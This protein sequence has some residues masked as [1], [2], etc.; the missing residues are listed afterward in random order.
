MVLCASAAVVWC[1]LSLLWCYRDLCRRARGQALPQLGEQ[2]A[3]FRSCVGFLTV[4]RCGD[5]TSDLGRANPMQPSTVRPVKAKTSRFLSARNP[6]EIPR[7]FL[8]RRLVLQASK[9]CL[10]RR[11][12]VGGA[13]QR[14]GELY[15]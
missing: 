2:P 6:C 5:L 8:A 9:E 10:T 4:Q 12:A 13:S 11:G 1:F 7:L 3:H 14:T 15:L